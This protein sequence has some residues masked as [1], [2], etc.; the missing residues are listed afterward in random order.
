[1]APEKV[2]FRYRLVEMESDWHQA[3]PYR[4]ATYTNLPPGQYHFLVQAANNS[5][6][7]S[8]TGASFA[9][10][11]IPAFTQTNAFLIICAVGG[12]LL[13]W[14]FYLMRVRQVAAKVKM[15]L[16]ARYAERARIANELHD[17]LLQNLS[18]FI[19]QLDGLI[20]IVSDPARAQNRIRDL[21]DQTEQS[22]HETREAI[23]NIR[24]R[25]SDQGFQDELQDMVDQIA[26]GQPVRTV[27]TVTGDR[28]AVEPALAG[29]LLRIAREATGNAIRHSGAKL[30]R[31]H[32][33]YGA[34]DTLQISIV[35]DGCG[36]DLE[37][38][39]RKMKHW[40]LS[41]MRERA[42]DIGAEFK[43]ITA[44]GEGTRI[45]VSVRSNSQSKL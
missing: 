39:S 23:W 5:G 35:D 28:R 10:S 31:V 18:G 3:G 9:F 41:S 16:E 19:L 36:F 37:Q 42:Q 26:K 25:S 15:R 17:D 44:P 1:V 2:N 7:W 27:I 38:G 45:E 40:G 43:I 14:A 8:N 6:V 21:R 29:Q 12:I 22:L 13:L 20:K 11:V 34:A 30:I 4:R 33:A 24:S 32:V